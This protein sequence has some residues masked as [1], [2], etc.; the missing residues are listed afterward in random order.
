M[1]REQFANTMDMSVVEELEWKEEEGRLSSRLAIA[2]SPR[3]D[4]EKKID[5]VVYF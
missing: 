3:Y 5:T 2:Q 1:K 4:D